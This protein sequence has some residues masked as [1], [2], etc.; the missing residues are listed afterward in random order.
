MSGRRPHL[1]ADL[2]DAWYFVTRS[3]CGS[4]NNS[5]PAHS[6][7]GHTCAT[8]GMRLRGCQNSHYQH[9]GNRQ[10]TTMPPSPVPDGS[11]YQ[12]E[13]ASATW[14][15][16]A[17]S[18]ETPRQNE[19]FRDRIGLLGKQVEPHRFSPCPS[20]SQQ[21]ERVLRADQCFHALFTGGIA[22]GLWTRDPD[23]APM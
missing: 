6:A 17:M 18:K 3:A 20:P 21:H 4:R 14:I 1:S 10:P 7:R 8:R 16:S 11:A 5:L 19:P 13:G 2:K 9:G 12:H 23:C 15:V 22:P